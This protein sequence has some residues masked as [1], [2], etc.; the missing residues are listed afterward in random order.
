M[1]I[2]KLLLGFFYRNRHQIGKYA[3]VGATSMVIDFGILYILTDIIGVYY[4][5]SA[6]ASFVVAAFYNYFLNR[7]WTFRSNGSRRKQLPVFFIIA[8]IGVTL[9]N[10]IMYAGVEQFGIWYIY[11]KIIATGIVTIWNFF[12]NKYLTFKIK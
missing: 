9:N 7:H 4:L 5:T 1:K 11:S 6:T 10:S 12:G 2:I 3:V 8:I